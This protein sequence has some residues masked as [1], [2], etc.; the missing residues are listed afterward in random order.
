[1]NFCATVIERA[2]RFSVAPGIDP[3]ALGVV[4]GAFR[5]GRAVNRRSDAGRRRLRGVADP[6]KPRAVDGAFAHRARGRLLARRPGAY[7]PREAPVAAWLARPIRDPTRAPRG[8]TVGGNR[9]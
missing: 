7:V 9:S 5:R 2:G 1:M 6:R 3:A 4:S 8:R